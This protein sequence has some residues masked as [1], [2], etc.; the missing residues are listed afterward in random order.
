VSDPNFQ[1]HVM[2]PLMEILTQYRSRQDL[3]ASIVALFE[4][5]DSDASGFVSCVAASTCFY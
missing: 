3:V 4:R 5:I 1:V 2:D